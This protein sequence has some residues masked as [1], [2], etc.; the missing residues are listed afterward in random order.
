MLH[1]IIFAIVLIDPFSNKALIAGIIKLQY[2]FGLITP[3]CPR[4]CKACQSLARYSVTDFFLW[5]WHSEGFLLA[6]EICSPFFYKIFPDQSG[7]F[8]LKATH[9]VC[10]HSNSSGSCAFYD[11]GLISRGPHIFHFFISDG[12]CQSVLFKG[13][14][15]IF[16]LY[17][18]PLH[19]FILLLMA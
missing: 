18:V 15:Y 19:Y 12:N 3:N 1:S 13:F 8:P 2:I 17:K 9:G 10:I 16:Q 5:Y 4:N 14:S 7:T 11:L 6:T